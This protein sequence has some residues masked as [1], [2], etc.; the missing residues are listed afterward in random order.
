MIGI[1]EEYKQK[2]NSEMEKYIEKMENERKSFAF[3]KI[4]FL[5]DMRIADSQ[6]KEEYRNDT[7]GIRTNR[8]SILQWLDLK[9][10]EASEFYVKHSNYYLGF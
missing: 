9:K 2:L 3:I 1:E 8:V 4:D 10:F 7:G 6:Y 5:V